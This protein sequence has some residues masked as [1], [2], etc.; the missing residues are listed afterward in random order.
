MNAGETTQDRALAWLDD[1]PDPDT[2]ADLAVLLQRADGS[3]SPTDAG[4]ALTELEDSFSGSLQFG[5]AGLRGRLGPGPNRMNAA[6]VR[7]AAAGLAAYLDSPGSTV[8]IGFDARHKSSLFASETAAVMAGAGLRPLVLP[9]PLPTPVLAF[10]ITHLE[11]AAGVMVTASHNPPEDNGYKVYLGD[12]TQIVPP[13]DAEIAERIGEVARVADLPLGSQ[14]ETLGEEVLEAYLTAAAAVAHDGGP[15]NLRLVFTSLHGVGGATLRAALVAAGF[16]DPEPVQAQY[17]PDPDFPTV[18]FPNPEEPGAM[19]AAL[20]TGVEHDADAVLA[21]DPDADRC[22]LAIR[23]RDGASFRMLRGDELGALLGWW[24]IERDQRVGRRTAGVF[25][26]SIVSSRLLGR[27]AAAGGVRHEETLT[28]FKWIARVRDL[29]F[30]Y[31]EALGYCVDP[32]NVA[33]KDGISAAVLVSEMLAD[34][35][36]RGRTAQDALDDLARQHGVHAT[37]QWA[38]RVSDVDLITAAMQ[39]LRSQPPAHFGGSAVTETDDLARGWR[40]LPPTEGIRYVTASGDRVIVRPSGTEPKIKAYLEVVQSVG[41]AGSLTQAAETAHH[42]LQ[43]L[44]K[45]I[46][47][48]SGLN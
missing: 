20:A 41:E 21:N 43:S 47:A 22:A 38:V 3:V 45:D 24:I 5:T 35:K 33:D 27:I 16:P 46:A 13:A 40:G 10:A 12:G 19:D 34:L 15:R 39:R 30:G 2:R 4:L 23:T 28:G 31:E 9:E 42:R 6:V 37:D 8:V 17:E 48:A 7:R 32:A 26:N 18:S 44:R 36:Y 1:D 14:W 11:C 29:R 25:A